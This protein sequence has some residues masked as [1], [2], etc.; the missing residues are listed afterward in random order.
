[1]KKIDI[2]ITKNV[3]G[4]ADKGI[5]IMLPDV[6]GNI[7]FIGYYFD[8]TTY[9]HITHVYKFDGNNATKYSF[10]ND[11]KYVINE[12]KSVFAAGPN[13]EIYFT[14]QVYL[15]LDHPTI[16]CINAQD[17]AFE[18]ECAN[19]DDAFVIK[20]FAA[21]TNMLF[22]ALA[23]GYSNYS[24]IH[25]VEDNL[26]SP[27]G[28]DEFYKIQDMVFTNTGDLLIIDGMQEAHI[29]D[30]EKSKLKKSFRIS[31]IYYSSYDISTLTMPM[32]I[33]FVD[34]EKSF[35]QV[36]DDH[37]K[38]LHE[39]SILGKNDH[40]LSKVLT[41]LSD[42]SMELAHVTKID[43]ETILL[44]LRDWEYITGDLYDGTEKNFLRTL[45][46]PTMELGPHPFEDNA[47]GVILSSAF[48]KNG[49][50]WLSQLGSKSDT[51]KIYKINPDNKR[52]DA[53]ETIFP[54]S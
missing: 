48:D 25:R 44:I 40:P 3:G 6:N 31:E 52:V 34:Y 17:E 1:M 12:Y 24:K 47:K 21:S 36:R 10:T 54:D 26:A 19:Y 30:V 49:T 23:S 14:P 5:C 46:L 8:Y 32:G 53:Q 51:T 28:L 18:I 27:L 22:C 42:H 39:I 11:K 7:W 29:I 13:G 50:L 9:E 4:I 33:V 16:V 15:S 2:Q 43:D 38:L 37:C 41:G 35:I 45:H 20:K